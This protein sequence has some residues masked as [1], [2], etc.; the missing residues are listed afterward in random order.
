MLTEFNIGAQDI[1]S[2]IWVIH[3]IL[4]PDP[5]KWSYRKCLDE[6]LAVLDGEVAVPCNLQPATAGS[7][8]APRPP[9]VEPV[10]PSGVEGWVPRNVDL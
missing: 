7:N 5:R 10:E 6:P 9:L 8:A 3:H 4:C 1:D 2:L